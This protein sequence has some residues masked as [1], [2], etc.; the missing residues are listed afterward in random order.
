MRAPLLTTKLYIPPPRSQLVS[1]QRLLR[2]L[3]T[4]LQGN[5]RL[6][7]LSAPAGFGKTTLLSEWIAACA[8]QPDR[9]HFAWVSLDEYDN[10]RDRFFSYF[11]AALQ[12]VDASLGRTAA[13]VLQAPLSSDATYPFEAILTSLINDLAVHPARLVVVLDDYHLITAPLIHTAISFLINH[14]PPHI[15]LVIAGRSDPPLPLSKWRA[16]DRLSEIRA[17]DLRFTLDETA[18]FVNHV[19]AL[20]LTADQVAQLETRV[21]GWIT[22]LQL[23]CRLAARP[24][25]YR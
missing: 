1:R 7:L 10:D 18:A 16:T 24:H 14:L 25:R 9:L 17:T 21:E 6:I 3:D 20:G 2:K 23:S 13:N 15:R 12:T 4:D 8:N 22:G 11:I 5:Q 19:T